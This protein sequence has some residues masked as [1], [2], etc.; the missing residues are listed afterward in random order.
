MLRDGIDY[1]LGVRPEYEGLRIDPCIPAAWRSYKVTRRFRGVTFHIR[2]D[3][4]QGVN[5]GVRR[6]SLNGQ[7]YEGTLI[8]IEEARL[9]GMLRQKSELDVVVEMG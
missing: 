6:I 8:R 5:K 7:P 1:I 3:N 4:P 9:A 2:V